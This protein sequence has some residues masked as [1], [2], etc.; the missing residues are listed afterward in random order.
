MLDYL[1]AVMNIITMGNVCVIDFDMS[2][3]LWK[4]SY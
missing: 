2:E 1:A 4:K 3:P